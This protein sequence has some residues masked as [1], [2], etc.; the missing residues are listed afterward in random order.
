M[1][2]LVSTA[3]VGSES[4]GTHD[5]ISLSH[6]SRSCDTPQLMWSVGRVNYCWS[7]PAQSFMVPW[8]YFVLSETYT[9]FEMESPHRRDEGSDY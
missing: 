2:V 1:L 5:H 9:C 6:D 4:R 7:L 3:I 8:P